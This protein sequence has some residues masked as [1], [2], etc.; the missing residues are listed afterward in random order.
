MKA[1]LF[2]KEGLGEIFRLTLKPEILRTFYHSKSPLSP[3]FKGGGLRDYF[4][5][6]AL[7]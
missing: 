5:F 1:P 4:S 3:F 2:D 6:W 7:I